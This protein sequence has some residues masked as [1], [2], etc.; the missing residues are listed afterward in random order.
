MRSRPK[1]TIDESH[2]LH[3]TLGKKGGKL[4]QWAFRSPQEE[5]Q[6]TE[7]ARG[8][9]QVLFIMI[10]EFFQTSISL[11]ASALTFSVILSLVPMLAMSTAV[12]KGMGSGDQLRTIAYRFIEELEPEDTPPPLSSNITENEAVTQVE[13]S[14]PADNDTPTGNDTTTASLDSYLRNGVETIFNYVENTNFAALGA[15]GTA[16]LL[17]VVILVFSS[18]EDAMNAIWHTKKGRSLFRK[19]MDYLALLILLPISINV[20]IAGDAILESPTMMGYITTFIPWPWVINMVFK[21][22]PFAFFTLTLL[23]MYLFFPHVKVKT[24][25]ALAGAVFGAI[26]WFIVQRSYLELQIG[27]SKYN[28]IYGSFATV[29]LVLVWIQLGWTFVLLGAVL[30]HAIQTR[31]QYRLVEAPSKARLELQCAFDLLLTVYNS[32]AG[33]AVTS[34]NKLQEAFPDINERTFNSTIELLSK[35]GLLHR[36]KEDDTIGLVPARPPERLTTEDVVRLVLGEEQ[37]GVS[38]GGTLADRIVQGAG[39]II[40][41][42]EFPEKYLTEG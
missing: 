8:G 15:F 6:I 16:G 9:L 1:P 41:A 21:L 5:A 10:Q 36:V 34:M 17:I 23:L 2:H 24:V 13:A 3:I 31:D 19:T 28:A 4:K 26:F 37:T 32:F 14:T 7:T 38:V 18:V 25:P 22:L 11:R 20:A 27:V 40:P 39:T 42:A 30:A 33:G 12:L 35:G 29:P